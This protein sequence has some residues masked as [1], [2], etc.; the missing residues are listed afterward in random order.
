VFVLVGM[1]PLIGLPMLVAG[2]LGL[3][4]IIVLSRHPGVALVGLVVFLPLQIP[5]FSVAYKYGVPGQLLEL[6]GSTKE[7]LGLAVVV[8]AAREVMKGRSKLDRL[9]KL[10]LA[11]VGL[12]LLYLLLPM[13]VSSS[14][15]PHSFSGRL[16][17]FRINAGFLLLFVAARHASINDRWRRRFVAAL[18]GMAV[19]LAGFGVYQYL[20]PRWFTNFLVGDLGVPFFLLDVFKS[21]YTEVVQLFRWTTASPV[22]VGSLFVGPFNFADFLLLPAAMLFDRLTRQRPRVRDIA[23]IALVGAALFAS[24]TR[25]DMLAFGVIALLALAPSPQRVLANR[26]RL[27]AIILLAVAA[28][29]PNLVATRLGGAS[30]SSQSTQGHFDEIRGGIDLL[31]AHPLGLGLGT[32]PAVAVRLE[33]APIVI[34][35]NSILQVGN[36]LGVVMMLLFIVILVAVVLR[37]GRANRDDPSNALAS[38]ARLAL[39][40]LLL[41][42]QLHHVFQ[43]FAITWPL[44]AAAGLALAGRTRDG[45]ASSAPNA[46][47]HGLPVAR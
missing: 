43:T 10:V 39:I 4:L 8:A 17:G 20:Q 30:G 40:G 16:L 41:A 31:A 45:G 34:S 12:M 7:V 22:R 26:L 47:T 19:V 28:F 32:A 13:V 2:A 23:F 14:T 38:S 18:I 27:L 1:S 11:Y 44:W 5:L 46:E 6:A 35:D 9:D 36:E 29:V 42:G 37:L 3:A 21:P 25:A 24:Q 15:Y 33:G